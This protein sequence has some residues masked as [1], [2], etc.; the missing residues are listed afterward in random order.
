M[1]KKIFIPQTL[2]TA[3]TEKYPKYGRILDMFEEANGCLAEW[4]NIS[5]PRLAKFVAFM[6]ERLARTS[7]KT[8]CAM[9]K[10][11]LNLYN[12]DVELPKGY[13]AI[14]SPKN[15]VSQQTWLTDKEIGK[16]LCYEPKNDTERL[17]KNQFCI[18]ALTGARHS[19]YCR[20]TNENIIGESL[21]YISQKSHVKAEIP[22]CPAVCRI[23]KEN[24]SYGLK[25]KTISA[26]TFNDTIRSVCR[27]SGISERIKLYQA[28]ELTEGEKWEYVTSHTAR[29]SFATN[30]YLRGAD[31]YSISV[32][33]GHSSTAM[34][35][36]YI[37]CGLRKMPE[38]VI[39]YFTQFT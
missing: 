29:R 17:V 33:M 34:T 20:F 2:K 11:V 39:A 36:R 28:G 24:E 14:L 23:L 30:L 35:E 38:N 31:L 8:Y 13:E 26:P 18:G 12:D 32:L 1:K 19:D 3:F 5:K 22:I 7:V 15:D 6:S 9:I 10:S 21:V 16:L 27:M 25:G 37:V 4:E